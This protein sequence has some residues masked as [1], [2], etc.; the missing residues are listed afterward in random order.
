MEKQIIK[1]LNSYN[2]DGL[3]CGG[4][5]RNIYLNL[6]NTHVDISVDCTISELRDKLRG[7]TEIDDY[8]VCVKAL[9][10][11]VPIVLYPRK[12]VELINTYYNYS[13]TKSLIDD[14]KSRDFTIN[15]LYYNPLTKVWI[16]TFNSRQDINNKVIKFIGDGTTKIL[17]SKIRIL[18]APV[19]ASILGDGWTI[20]P[21]TVDAIYTNR[22]KLMTVNSKQIY[23]ELDKIFKNATYPSKFFKFLRFAGILDDFFPELKRCIDIEQ[24][25]KAENLDLFNHIML[26][27]DSISSNKSNTDILRIAALLHDIGKPYTEVKTATGIHFYNHENVG[28]YLTEKILY[29]WGFPKAIINKVMLLV[30]NHLFDA[31]PNKT[32]ISVKKLINKVGAEHI[33]DLLDLRIA[34]RF[35]TGRKDISMKNIYKLRDKINTVLSEINPAQFKL[36]ITDNQLIQL[37]G[38]GKDH[39]YILD[40]IK[41]YLEFRIINNNLL[42]K[43]ATLKKAAQKV[44]NIKC[45]LGTYHLF[46]TQLDLRQGNAILFPDGRVECGIFCNFLC[47]NQIKK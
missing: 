18:R 26:T 37:L 39:T 4:T 31:S 35:G 23:P 46:K 32:M 12:K 1:F 24:S 19:F 16:D 10:K 47:N 30:S 43:E 21:E 25:N 27:L 13:F 38:L 2:I 7:I 42:N 33:H 29:R 20:S 5:A 45:P 3:I 40:I 17:E 44:N 8:N 6:P 36:Q 22:L 11:D 34:D 41:R 15:A 14:A 28:A 9:Y